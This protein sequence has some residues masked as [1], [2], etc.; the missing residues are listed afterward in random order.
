MPVN[1]ERFLADFLE[2][3]RIPS[4]SG[5][6]KEVAKVV[7][8]K[9]E[10]LGLTVE[11]DQAHKA[12]GGEQGN[13]IVKVHG[14]VEG[15]ETLFFNAH[16]DTVVP[17]EDVKP[18]VEGD[19]VRSDGRT[20]LG[21]DNKAGV[22]VLIEFLRILKEDGINHGPIEIAFTVAEEVGLLGA[23]HLDYSRIS[24]KVGFVLDSGPPINKVIVQAPSQKNL[25]AVVKGKAAHAG[26]SPEKGINAIQLASKAIAAMRIG[27]ID[28]ET[29]ANIGVIRGGLATNIVPEEVEILGEARSHDPRKLEEQI[30]HMVTLIESEAQRGGG[31]ADVEIT[32]VYRSFKISEDD[33]PAKLIKSALAKMGYEPQWEITGG[34]SDA[35]VFN[36]QGIKCVVICCG[37]ESPHSPENE[38]LDI[39]SALQSVDLLVNLVTINCQ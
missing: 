26:V 2:L 24:A 16:L 22:C 30:A 3:V 25:H 5:K 27:R 4:P 6:E 31:K 33:P 9:L 14:S 28:Q 19:K 12:F 13:L 38:R 21:A 34:G 20:I 23:K 36:S 8:K 29:T 15:A 7:K 39:T 10:D 11:E 17:C 18:I 1:R 35:N 32:D 37:E